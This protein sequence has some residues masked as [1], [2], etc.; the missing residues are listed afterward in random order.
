[1]RSSKENWRPHA[2]ARDR[3]LYSSRNNRRATSVAERVPS[4]SFPIPQN[5]AE[6]LKALRELKLLNGD[7]VSEFDALCEIVQDHFRVPIAFVSFIDSDDQVL[8]G[9]CG[10]GASVTPRDIAF[11]NHAIMEK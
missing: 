6:R 2:P 9:R 10:I 3:Y 11:C 8:K 1:M 4:M 7:C 5:K